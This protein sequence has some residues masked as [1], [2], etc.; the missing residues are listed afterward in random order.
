MRKSK[1]VKFGIAG[2][3]TMILFGTAIMASAAALQEVKTWSHVMTG[4]SATF[5][6]GHKGTGEWGTDPNRIIR[7]SWVAIQAGVNGEL[8]RDFSDKVAVNA[9]GRYSA[10]KEHFN[11][12]FVTTYKYYGWNY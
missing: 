11:N 12:P 5:E 10:S 1:I 2:I 3:L 4:I 7:Q 8:E 6:A 9:V